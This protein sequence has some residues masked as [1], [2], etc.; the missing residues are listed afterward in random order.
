MNRELFAAEYAR[1]K[2]K[3]LLELS[4]APFYMERNNAEGVEV[5][6]CRGRTVF[7]EEF[8]FPDEFKAHQREDV[9]NRAVILAQFLV[10]LS[11]SSLLTTP[12]NHP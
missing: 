10:A 2:F 6:D 5:R 12:P 7:A 4:P 11:E 9:V 3:E 8:C 1:E